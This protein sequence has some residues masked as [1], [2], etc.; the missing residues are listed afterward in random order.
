MNRIILS[1]VIGTRAYTSSLVDSNNMTC[2]DIVIQELS[3]VDSRHIFLTKLLV[4]YGFDPDR[5]P[6]KVKGKKMCLRSPARVLSELYTRY[7]RCPP[8]KAWK[9]Q[10]FS[11]LTSLVKQLEQ[12]TAIR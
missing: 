12:T 2:L 9:K 3:L 5:K 10:K 4:D 11:C 7:M 1:K 6:K 8:R